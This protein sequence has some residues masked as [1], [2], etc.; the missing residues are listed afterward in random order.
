MR[1]LPRSHRDELVGKVISHA[2][3]NGC[4]S[5][6]DDI[7][8]RRL[9]GSNYVV[10]LSLY[11]RYLFRRYQP[12]LNGLIKIRDFIFMRRSAAAELAKAT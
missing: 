1:V 5:Y 11:S 2:A 6:D 10:G 4:C 9:A 3:S 12:R 7:A 8:T